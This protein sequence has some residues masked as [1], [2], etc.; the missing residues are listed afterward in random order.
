MKLRKKKEINIYEKV[1]TSLTSQIENLPPKHPIFNFNISPNGCLCRGAVCIFEGTLFVKE[2]NGDTETFKLSHFE[3]IYIREYYN[4]TGVEATINGKETEL[5]RSSTSLREDLKGLTDEFADAGISV[6][7][8]FN[9]EGKKQG[10]ENLPEGEKKAEHRNPEGEKKAEHRRPEGGKNPEHGRPHGGKKPMGKCPKCGKRLRPRE[11]I[12]TS[13]TSKKPLIKWLW[14]FVSPHKVKILIAVGLFFLTSALQIVAPKINRVIIDDYLNLAD[15]SS[16]SK[17]TYLAWVALMAV[18]ALTIVFVQVVRSILMSKTG[19]KIAIGIKSMVFHKIQTL[20]M[21]NINKR[22][23]GEYISRISHDT[24]TVKQCIVGIL[25]QILQQGIILLTVIPVMCFIN[26]ILALLVIIPVPI[27][28]LCFYFSRQYIMKIYHK[29]WQAGTESS[30]V[31]HDIFQGIRIVKSFGMEKAE[32]KRYCDVSTRQ[33]RIEERNETMWNMIMPIINFFMSAGEYVVL[34]FAG[35]KVLDGITNPG[36]GMTIGQISELMSYVAIVYGP[37]RWMAGVPRQ[38]SR[39]LTSG[40]KLLEVAE[41]DPAVEESVDGVT[42]PIKGEICFKD[43]IFGYDEYKPVLKGANFTVK[44]GEM[45]GLVG[46]SGVG[47]STAINL[48]MRLYD[49]REGSVSIDG[50]NIKDYSQSYLRS[51]IGVVLQET[52]LFKGTVESNIRYAKPD[53][54]PEEIIAAAKMAH[55]HEFIMKLPDGYNTYISEK[56]MSLSGGERQ[57]IAIARAVLRN[58][59]IL[60][61]DEATAALDI[62]TE[63]LIQDSLEKI[64]KGKTTVAIAHR[65]S[66]LR[67]ANKIVVLEEGK[68]EEEGTHKELLKNEGRYYKLVNAQRKMAE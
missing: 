31:L 47:K 21:E 12:C 27:I 22:M 64:T 9:K 63:K 7:G 28:V 52:Y 39:A 13:C 43:V 42:T 53:A 25:P 44:S 10:E 48:I 17:S 54:T 8:L 32:E 57:R 62:E 26:P 46:R 37:I 58:P 18:T 49:A 45:V 35:Y 55:A 29:Q 23:A 51:R 24:N 38:I 1:N 14:Q 56:G 36:S 11:T 4:S 16:A 3:K 65:L 33:A 50:V 34:I 60:I 68:V 59:D 40:F 41:E 20:S 2:E 66:T 6:Y 19:M 5:F 15:K 67:N 30:N 61:L